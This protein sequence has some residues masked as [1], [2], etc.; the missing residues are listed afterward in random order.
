MLNERL[1][2]SVSHGRNQHHLRRQNR[3]N[4]CQSKPALTLIAKLPFTVPIRWEQ[5]LYDQED[6][7]GAIH[8]YCALKGDPK[9]SSLNFLVMGPCFH[10][11]INRQGRALGPFAIWSFESTRH[12]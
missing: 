2:R 7:W 12:L 5:G 3:R 4:C 6:M 8:S 10:S 9:A 11:Q 1:R